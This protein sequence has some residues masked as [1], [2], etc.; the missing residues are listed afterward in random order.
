MRKLVF[1]NNAAFRLAAPIS[2]TYDTATLFPDRAIDETNIGVG[3]VENGVY[4]V[5]TITHSSL[6]GVH[7]V[8][9]IVAAINDV[10]LPP[11]FTAVRGC[12]GTTPQAWPT[13]ADVEC[14]VTRGLLGSL[15]FR[16]DFSA[17]DNTVAING[18]DVVLVRDAEGNFDPIPGAWAFGGAPISPARGFG[19]PTPL[20]CSVEGVGYSAVVELGELPTVAPTYVPGNDYRPGDYVLVPGTPPVVW[21][22]TRDGAMGASQ[23]APGALPWV[24]HPMSGNTLAAA[25]TDDPDVWFYPTEIGFLCE[26]YTATSTPA[27]TVTEVP[28]DGAPSTLVT[29]KSLSALSA[30]KRVVVSNTVVKGI[31]GLRINLVTA[32]AG[33]SCRGRFYWKGLFIHSAAG[34]DS[35]GQEPTLPDGS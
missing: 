11:A 21:C 31:Q 24:A 33:G 8:V 35:A 29:S 1:F 26:A 9:H 34:Y 12:E 27:V 16:S 20:A 22:Y 3:P 2:A 14:R 28:L 30:N 18:G 7:E 5:A 4:T 6:P 23:A 25:S 19:E 13:S 32:A 15:N 17:R 10:E